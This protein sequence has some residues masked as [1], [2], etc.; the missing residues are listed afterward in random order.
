[1]A[2]NGPRFLSLLII[3]FI[4]ADLPIDV[5]LPN[6]LKVV[7]EVPLG[8]IAFIKPLDALSCPKLPPGNPGLVF[9]PRHRGPAVPDISLRAVYR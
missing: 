2:E 1:M 5:L 8:L 9:F 4:P 3:E 6:L 7:Q